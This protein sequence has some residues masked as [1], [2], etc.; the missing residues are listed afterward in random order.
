MP[1]GPEIK[2]MVDNVDGYIGTTLKKIEFVSGRYIHHG[3]PKNFSDL[4]FPV[5]ASNHY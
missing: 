4:I 3:P 5:Q 1:E 2:S